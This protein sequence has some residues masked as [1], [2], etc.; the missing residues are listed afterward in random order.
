MV[1]LTRTSI[2][3]GHYVARYAQ[4]R[5]EGA[6]LEAFEEYCLL[7]PEVAEQVQTD[8]ALLLGLQALEP[9]RQ[10]TRRPIYALAAGIALVVAGA[11]LWTT[12]RGPADTALYALGDALPAEATRRITNPLRVVRVRDETAQTLTVPMDATAAAL[13]IEPAATH[14]EPVV[15]VVLDEEV[16]GKWRTRGNRAAVASNPDDGTVQVVIDLTKLESV[17]L[18]VKL[19]GRGEKSD[20]FYLRIERQTS[21]D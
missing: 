16:E 5:L 17:H 20:D 10:V 6:E 2:D 13:D 1:E 15:D 19:R 8:R 18:R 4:G 12:V 9:K 11:V 7:H 3:E 14:G 21:A